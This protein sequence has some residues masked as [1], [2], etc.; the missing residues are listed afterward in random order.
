[1]TNEKKISYAVESSVIFL[2]SITVAPPMLAKDIVDLNMT[3]FI[4]AAEFLGFTSYPPAYLSQEATAKNIL[5]GANFASGASGFYPG[6][7]QS[8]VS[9]N[10]FFLHI[11]QHLW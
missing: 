2:L 7:P 11:C 4:W 6:T 1:M 3:K 5:I 9:Q 10:V 8:Y